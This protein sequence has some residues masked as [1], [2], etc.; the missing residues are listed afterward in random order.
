MSKDDPVSVKITDRAKTTATVKARIEIVG[1]KRGRGDDESRERNGLYWQ[2]I[3]AKYRLA[4]EQSE[5]HAPREERAE[6][7]QSDVAE[8]DGMTSARLTFDEVK[9]WARDQNAES[10]L[11]RI[12]VIRYDD[13]PDGF[14][15][16]C[17]ITRSEKKSI[18]AWYKEEL[19]WEVAR[20]ACLG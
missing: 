11:R 13:D 8:D 19:K 15:E 3:A 9:S 17:Y 1:S 20:V 4:R 7:D 18:A 12:K 6:G 2:G 5:D 10:L 14:L 16:D